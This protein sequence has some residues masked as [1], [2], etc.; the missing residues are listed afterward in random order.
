MTEH[1]A[2]VPRRGLALPVLLIA[3]VVLIVATVFVVLKARD[4]SHA[5]SVSSER[6]Q[7][8][9]IAGQYAVDF[10]SID[11]R[12]F[13]QDTSANVKHASAG[14]AKTYLATMKAFKPIYVKGKIVT[15][16]TVARSAITTISK[17]SAVVLVAL[18]GTT[19]SVNTKGETQ[20][21]DRFQITLSKVDGSWLTSNVTT[22]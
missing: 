2:E 4:V 22:I 19:T 21:L 9:A 15:T 16:T 6:K 3:V 11:Y 5:S 14:F 20:Q 17:T 1:P 18:N 10:T 8:A 7:I 12:Q 13:D